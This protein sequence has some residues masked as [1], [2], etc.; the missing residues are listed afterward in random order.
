VGMERSDV[1]RVQVVGKY[2]VGMERS[3]VGSEQVEGDIAWVWSVVMWPVSKWG[4]FRVGM[5]RSNVCSKQVGAIK[6]GY[7]TYLCGQKARGGDKAWVCSVVI[8]AVS[9]GGI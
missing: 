7:G 2:S 1:C 6:R 9:K 5:E 8:S 3:D 4:G